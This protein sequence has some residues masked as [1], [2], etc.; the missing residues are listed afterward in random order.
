MILTN[1]QQLKKNYISLHPD[2]QQVIT[3]L[4]QYAE[5]FASVPQGKS[6]I[7]D[8]RL[9]CIKVEDVGRGKDSSPL[10]THKK[11]IDIQYTVD[12]TDIIGWRNLN[13]DDVKSGDG[14]D[15]ENDIEFYVS[16]IPD[17]WI[18]VPKGNIAIF[19]P[20]DMH[21]PMACEIDVKKLVIKVP[22]E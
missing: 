17:T 3:V 14:Y 13:L 8:C 12:G 10:E 9:M 16:V 4:S 15:P 5:D 18:E 1:L 20:E 2:F 6:L 19:F 11:Y 22:V 7:S 21:A